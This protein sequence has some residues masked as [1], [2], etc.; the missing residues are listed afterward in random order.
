[1]RDASVDEII[2]HFYE[3]V[4]V[5]T[6][7][8][9]L[10]PYLEKMVSATA[11]YENPFVYLNEFFDTAGDNYHYLSPD[12]RSFV[13]GEIL[14]FLDFFPQ[15]YS[16]CIVYDMDEPSLVGD[17]IV[18]NPWYCPDNHEASQYLKSLNGHID[19]FDFDDIYGRFWIAEASLRADAPF[20]AFANLKK[21][22]YFSMRSMN[23]VAA[24][25]Y[26]ANHWRRHPHF[27]IEHYRQDIQEELED[28]IEAG[29]W[30]EFNP[31]S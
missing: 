6:D 24:T 8:V 17:I 21:D 23:A 4:I 19:F 15:E 1:M 26:A 25:V 5:P 2:D 14:S 27:R 9:P 31:F 18:N 16:S 30:I 7:I 20:P 22:S 3:S 10:S 13:L 28:F 11:D 12:V 29:D